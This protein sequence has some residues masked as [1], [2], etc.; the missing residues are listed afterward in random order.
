M[1]DCEVKD[2]LPHPGESSSSTEPKSIEQ[3]RYVCSMGA[4]ASVLAI[5]GVIPI[6][7]CGPGCASKQ[8][9]SLAGINGYQG[10]EFH[11][12]STNI[13]ERDVVFGGT[14]RLKEL[15]AATLKIMKADLFVV[16]TG[17]VPELVGDDVGN[18]V[19]KF[20]REGAAIVYAETGGFRGN[21]F[22]GHERI[23]QAIIDQ[24]VG[25]YEGPREIGSVNVWSM[26]PYQNTFWRGDLSEIKRILQ[27]IGLKVNILFGPECQGVTEWKAV[28][29]A[30]FNLVLSPWLGLATA[31]RLE[32]KYGQPFLH[33]PVV[34]IGARQT[35]AFL[36][37]VAEFAGLD[38]SRAETFITDEE[39][40]YYIYLRDF[41]G[42][43]GGCT[44]QYQLPSQFVVIG[45][46]A[47][48]LAVTKFLV[49]QLGLVPGRQIITDNPPEEFRESIRQEYRQIAADV[50]AD[51]EFEEDG[52]TIHRRIR[53]TDFHYHVP[54]LFGSTWEGELAKQVGGTLVEIGFPCT[55]EVVL[56]RSYVGY[57][58]ALA[59]IERTYTTVVRA[60]TL[61]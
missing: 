13:T 29:E 60:S 55:D 37:Q 22:T 8:F 43:Y 34:P 50:A 40:L 41:A 32:Q 54:I 38:R 57:R 24:Y 27:G 30:Q 2:T 1:T 14:D 7:H 20:Q 35:S 42:F 31:R 9:T 12:P 21:N 51:V 46:S 33:V 44:S 25:D 61:V 26:L 52:Y 10:G 19:G 53:E 23:T 49:N 6:T 15:I 4:L 47:Y 5:P 39:R 17:C 28:P 36:R 56:S 3:V 16:L 58:G 18:A 45:E 59:L 11:V 48:N